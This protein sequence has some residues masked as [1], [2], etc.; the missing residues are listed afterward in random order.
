MKTVQTGLM[1]KL[2]GGSRGGSGGPNP[3]QNNKNIGFL[4]NTGPDPMKK[5]KATKPAF[6]VGPFC[7]PSKR[8][9]N[10]VSLVGR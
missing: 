3:L 2:M 6:N 9:F 8:H 1:P 4:C 5:H 10:G 7:P